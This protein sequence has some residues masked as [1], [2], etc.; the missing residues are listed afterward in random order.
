[1]T[2]LGCHP[3]Y[4]DTDLQRRGPEQMGSTLRRYAMTVANKLLAQDSE[5][6]ALPMLY[7]ATADGF[8]GG[9]YIGPDGVMNMRG[10]PTRD[11]PSKRARDT[12][13]ADQLWAVSEK[14]TGVTDDL[15]ADAAAIE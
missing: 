6:G 10:Y 1:V 5:H 3:G 7:A 15:L 4:S 12:E 14:E 11:T 8:H 2:S 9:E 13:T